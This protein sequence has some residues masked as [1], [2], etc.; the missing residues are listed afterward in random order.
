MSFT[1]INPLSGFVTRK[2]TYPRQVNADFLRKQIL[3]MMEANIK[4]TLK[5]MQMKQWKTNEQLHL[6]KLEEHL[7]VLTNETKDRHEVKARS[8]FSRLD[9][10]TPTLDDVSDAG[11][12][13]C[14]AID[15]LQMVRESHI[16]AV[17]LISIALQNI[18]EQIDLNKAR[19]QHNQK[20]LKDVESRMNW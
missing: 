3:E 13:I 12:E 5:K 2:L 14:Q 7:D 1:F 19:I 17:N 6:F 8:R 15:I 16:K 18:R 10:K 20:M 4:L 9:G 11:Y